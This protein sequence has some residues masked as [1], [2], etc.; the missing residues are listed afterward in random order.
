MKYTIFLILILKI[1]IIDNLKLLLTG[2]LIC[3]LRGFSKERRRKK[4][5]E[6]KIEEIRSLP[7]GCAAD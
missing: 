5:F 3:L 1:N 6:N 7:F 2:D 4:M